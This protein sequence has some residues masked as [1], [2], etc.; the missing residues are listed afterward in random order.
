MGIFSWNKRVRSACKFV[1]GNL[2]GRGYTGDVDV[3]ERVMK[4]VVYFRATL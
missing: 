1:V 2:L 4:L 3:G